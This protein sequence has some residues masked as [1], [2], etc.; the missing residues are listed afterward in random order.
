MV[1]QAKQRN[2]LIGRMAVAL[3]QAVE[4]LIASKAKEE[5]IERES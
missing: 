2:E 4:Q 1:P 3:Y 5:A